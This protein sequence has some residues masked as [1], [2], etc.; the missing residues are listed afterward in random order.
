[1]WGG[2]LYVYQLGER[3]WKWK[4]REFFRRSVI[5]KMG[6]LIGYTKG[7]YVLAKQ[8]YGARGSYHRCFFYTSNMYRELAALESY[9]SCINILVGN[10]ADPSNNHL[11]VFD[12]LEAFKDKDIKIYAPLSYGNPDYAKRI[13]EQGKLRFGDKFEALTEHIPFNEYLEFLGKIDVAIFNHK[14]QQAMGNIRTLLGLGKKVYMRNDI[15]SFESLK[16]DGIKVFTLDEIN[17]DKNFDEMSD[18]QLKVKRNFSQKAL[19][20]CLSNIW[21]S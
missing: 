2:D 16:E 18:N 10:S 8:W 3:N 13:I 12:K 4:L 19:V 14:R 5:K 11:D 20:D 15:T 9:H 1:M 17:L 7:D 21:K 6:H